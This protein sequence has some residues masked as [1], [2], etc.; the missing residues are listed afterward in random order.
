MDL[1]YADV[2]LCTSEDK[3]TWKSTATSIAI[4][5]IQQANEF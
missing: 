4:R 2:H 1:G 5:L 3:I